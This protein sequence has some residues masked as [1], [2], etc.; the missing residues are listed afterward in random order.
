MSLKSIR[1]KLR[2]IA[3][4]WA[5]KLVCVS[6]LIFPWCEINM[7]YGPRCVMSM[8][9]VDLQIFWLEKLM[10]IFQFYEKS[11]FLVFWV[12]I[13]YFIACV[14]N[15][16]GTQKIKATKYVR[17]NVIQGILLNV[18]VA[19]WYQIWVLF[20]IVLRESLFGLSIANG[21]YL[22]VHGAMLYIVIHV[23]YGKYA[24]MPIFSEG[25]RSNIQAF[26]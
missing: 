24:L 19:A 14:Y 25:A 22:F 20:P 10:P 26:K 11:L 4:I 8:H 15:E 21:M 9:N 3:K 18:F 1:M 16:W 5:T 23:I 17:F 7:Y 12:M 6:S 13:S 2:T